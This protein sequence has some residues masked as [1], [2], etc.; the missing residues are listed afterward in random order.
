VA[1][2]AGLLARGL[3]DRRVCL[4][5][6][7][8][9]LAALRQARCIESPTLRCLCARACCCCALSAITLCAAAVHAVPLLSTASEHARWVGAGVQ[10]LLVLYLRTLMLDAN[11][12]A[13]QESPHSSRSAAGPNL[14]L[15]G[16]LSSITMPGD[17]GGD[18]RTFSI[19]ISSSDEEEGAAKKA[20]PGDGAR[21]QTARGL[22]E[23]D[24]VARLS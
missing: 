2:P 4:D 22:Q 9:R 16:D 11:R 21:V 3:P 19:H 5:P 8:S 7:G 10:L 23:F 6:G 15:R 24:G 17:S 20:G 18:V 14:N 1:C 13:A 12:L